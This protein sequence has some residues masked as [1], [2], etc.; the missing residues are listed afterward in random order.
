MVFN[1]RQKKLI[2][3]MFFAGLTLF[4]SC[5]GDKSPILSNV[6]G[7]AGEVVVV[8][9]DPVW[10]SEAGRALGETLI[11]EY[12]ALPQ[13][14][15]MFDVVRIRH[16]AFS[17]IFKTHRNIIVVNVSDHYPD[18]RMNIRTN[19]WAKPQILLE[20]S[21][22]STDELHSFVINHGDRI[23][24]ELENTEIDRIK[25]YNKQY[26]KH[27]I[28]EELNNNFDLSLTFPPG[29]V[30]AIDTTDFA[31][32][33][34]NP[35]TKELIQGI[36]VYHYD[37]TE[38]ETFTADFLV[39]K[40]NQFLKEYVAG[41]SPNS[42]MTTEME[43]FPLFDEYMQDD[44]YFARLRGL[45]KVRN[46]FMGGPFISHTTL[47]EKRNRVITVEG[48]VFEPGEKKRDLVRQVEAIISSLDI[49]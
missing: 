37:Y 9:N 27:S 30:F 48:F 19:V 14:E 45:W 5:S 33:V 20:I 34:F 38:P 32:L 24:M 31:W 26:E 3:F 6:T 23:L 17:N 49:H 22:T 21:A 47:D 41:P 2:V 13:L 7:R 12:P 42:F 43:L 11:S 18:T 36:F 44:R 1:I 35:P 40:R 16:N 10:E 8:I 29:Y 15:Y 25:N 4:I 39:E 28:R 46:D